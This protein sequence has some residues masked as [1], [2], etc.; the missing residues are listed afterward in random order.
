M[1]FSQTSL[2]NSPLNSAI[3]ELYFDP[4]PGITRDTTI[5]PT[6]SQQ[7]NLPANFKLGQSVVL[8]FVRMTSST[9]PANNGTP[10]IYGIFPDSALPPSPTAGVPFNPYTYSSIYISSDNGL[11]TSAYM[12]L[13]YNNE[14]R[15]DVKALYN[16]L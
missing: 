2:F 3:F 13:W 15:S 16:I 6:N 5:Q 1:S 4:L 8:G 9:N 11:D 14:P 12:L 10:S 7:T